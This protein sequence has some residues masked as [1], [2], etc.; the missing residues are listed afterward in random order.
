MLCFLAAGPAR[1][2][3][4]LD[5]S[6]VVSTFNF[7]AAMVEEVSRAQT[8]TVGI[9]GLLSQV[10]LEIYQSTGT[11]VDPTFEI[12]G[13]TGGVPDSTK[14]LFTTTIPLSIVPIFDTP[15]TGTVPMT[16]IDV[17][18]A[19]ILVTPGEVLS[20]ALSRA[21]FGSPP[22]LLW[23]YGIGGYAGGDAYFSAPPGSPWMVQNPY[24]AG[25]QTYVSAVPEPSTAVLALIGLGCLVL[26]VRARWLSGKPQ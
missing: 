24:E 7:D 1:A 3:G 20:L 21:A 6:N 4:T 17:S 25:F 15:P 5:Q 12:L 13:T 19:G 8:F 2:G 10:N 23:R 26:P 16:S 18:S 11:T 22:W 9:A 14:P